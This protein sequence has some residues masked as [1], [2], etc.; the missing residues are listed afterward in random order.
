MYMYIPRVKALSPS[1]VGAPAKGY[2]K[3]GPPVTFV[4]MFMEV[5]S[6]LL[7]NFLEVGPMKPRK[8]IQDLSPKIGGFLEMI[9]GGWIYS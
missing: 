9:N 5:C 4:M 7:P 1:E 2:G 8:F 3:V 6:L